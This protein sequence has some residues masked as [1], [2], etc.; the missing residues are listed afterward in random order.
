MPLA[1]GAEEKKD[2]MPEIL[3]EEISVFAEEERYILKPDTNPY[4]QVRLSYYQLA[5]VFVFKLHS[6]KVSEAIAFAQKITVES[7]G[8][9][10]EFFIANCYRLIKEV[11]LKAYSE[12]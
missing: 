2:E 1:E 5:K 3:V 8:H 4:Y 9:E 6:S 12:R 10:E 11:N 7:Q